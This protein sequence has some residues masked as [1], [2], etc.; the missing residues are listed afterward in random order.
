M[1]VEVTVGFGGA[2][3]DDTSSCA[4]DDCCQVVDGEAL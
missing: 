3:G 2:G 1:E 4:T